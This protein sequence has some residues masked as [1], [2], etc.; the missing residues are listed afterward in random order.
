MFASVQDTFSA[1]LLAFIFAFNEFLFALMLTTGPG[2]IA[3]VGAIGFQLLSTPGFSTAIVGAWFAITVISPS[4]PG[5]MTER[6]FVETR[7][8]SGD[9]MAIAA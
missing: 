4:E 1:A 2:E 6:A 9:S 5:I 7:R 8:R 3:P